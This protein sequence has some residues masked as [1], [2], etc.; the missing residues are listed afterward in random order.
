MQIKFKLE[1]ETDFEGLNG[2]EKVL[3]GAYWIVIPPVETRLRPIL[4]Y[5]CFVDDI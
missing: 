5:E 1:V 4:R 3:V 2:K